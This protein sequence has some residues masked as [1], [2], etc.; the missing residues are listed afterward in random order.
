MARVGLPAAQVIPG[1]LSASALEEGD[2]EFEG[3]NEEDRTTWDTIVGISLEGERGWSFEAPT[4]EPEEGAPGYAT[5]RAQKE[6][7]RSGLFRPETVP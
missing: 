6:L 2:A 1:A 4:A 3:E 5:E 7:K